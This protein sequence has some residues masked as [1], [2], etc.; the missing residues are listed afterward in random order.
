[1][2]KVKE[3]IK[4]TVVIKMFFDDDNIFDTPRLRYN[5]LRK[6]F[7]RKYLNPKAWS[8]RCDTKELA[9]AY[10]DLIEYLEKTEHFR[11]LTP[12]LRTDI[13]TD[14]INLVIHELPFPRK[15]REELIEF[16]VCGMRKGVE[17]SQENE[18]QK[19]KEYLEIK[20]GGVLVGVERRSNKE[21]EDYRR[22]AKEVV[23]FNEDMFAEV[24][25]KETAEVKKK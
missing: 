4:A 5:K 1:M 12:S 24:D 20:K 22:A 25:N 10:H 9:Q 21:I 13:P 11:C 6:E 7:Y 19:I 8:Y 15:R 3:N 23:H 17:Q 16:V 2:K 14:N 18:L